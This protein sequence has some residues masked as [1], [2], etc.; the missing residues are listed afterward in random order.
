HSAHRPGSV[1]PACRAT[2]GT[3][4]AAS[5]LVHRDR[6]GA[7]TA[8]ARVPTTGPGVPAGLVAGSGLRRATAEPALAV[9]PV[10]HRRRRRV[11]AL[12]GPIV[13]PGAVLAGGAIPATRPA[14]P[15]APPPPWASATDA[16]PAGR[17]I[18]ARWWWAGRRAT[19]AVPGARLPGGP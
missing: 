19:R 7:T 5:R 18:L 15:H 2:R 16:R 1:A 3:R 9:G 13:A 8:A 12:A 10:P 6:G 17:P 4:A 14:A 11:G